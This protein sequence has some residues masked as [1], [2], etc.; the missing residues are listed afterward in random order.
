MVAFDVE[1]AEIFINSNLT[2]TL[3]WKFGMHLR[4]RKCFKPWVPKIKTSK[5]F[6]VFSEILAE[7]MH[8]Y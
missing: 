8:I 7:F 5:K 3:L 1:E 2:H 6:T 4:E